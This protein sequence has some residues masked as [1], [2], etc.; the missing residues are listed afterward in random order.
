MVRYDRQCK[1]PDFYGTR[2][3]VSVIGAFLGGS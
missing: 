3:S 1:S 2:L